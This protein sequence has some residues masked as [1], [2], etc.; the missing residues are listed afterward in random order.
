[1]AEPSGYRTGLPWSPARGEDGRFGLILLCTVALF[2]PPAIWIPGLALPEPEHSDNVDVP[3]RLAKLIEQRKPPKPVIVPDPISETE[4]DSMADAPA[5]EPQEPVHQQSAPDPMPEPAQQTVDQ[6]REKAREKASRSGL[7]AMKGQLTALRSDDPVRDRRLIANVSDSVA[8]RQ[9]GIEDSAAIL[10]GSGGVTSERG[11]KRQV[12]VEG[13]QVREVTAAR[14]LAPEAVGKPDPGPA[15]RGMSNI[16]KVF[17]AQKTALYSLYRRELRQD[18]TLEGKVLLEL[19]I[20]PDGSVSRCEVVSSELDN[21]ELER[22]IATRVQLFNFGADNVAA[23]KVK[24][25]IDF[26]PG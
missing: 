14:E 19:V 24:F 17:D 26:L 16:R 13:H 5:P 7:L 9:S 4:Q 21:P 10:Q 18:P 25:P 12:N 6:A 15:E 20:E 11:P 8:E 22:R 3:P 23:R 1:M 2:L